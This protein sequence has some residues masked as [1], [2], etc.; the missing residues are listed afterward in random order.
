LALEIKLTATAQKYFETLDKP[1]QKR[2]REKLNAIALAPLD[3]RL[4]K[5][6]VGASQRT[7][8]VGDYRILFEVMKTDLFV[9]DIAPRGRAYRRLNR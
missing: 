8:R 1:T 3:P 6:L 5:P 7:A 2:V 4:S 9:S